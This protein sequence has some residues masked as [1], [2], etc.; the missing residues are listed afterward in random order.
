VYRND[1]VPTV[2]PKNWG[3]NHQ[4]T[5][6]HFYD[7]TGYLAYPK[8]TDDSPIMRPGSANDHGGYFCLVST[9]NAEIIQ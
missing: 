6:I 3:F 5:E 8:Y 9:D 1:P 4:G 2:P 7:C